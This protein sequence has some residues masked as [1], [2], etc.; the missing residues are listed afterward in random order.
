MELWGEVEVEVWTCR[1]RK[2]PLALHTQLMNQE[3]KVVAG[4]DLCSCT[5]HSVAENVGD[6]SGIWAGDLLVF[7]QTHCFPHPP[8]T[9]GWC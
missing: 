2:D 8:A 3:S 7:L 9:G 4:V 5:L 6:G 1:A